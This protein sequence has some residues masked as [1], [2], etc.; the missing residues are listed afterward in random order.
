M[1]GTIIA[2]TLF[3]EVIEVGALNQTQ[4]SGLPACSRD[5][6]LCLPRLERQADS[7]A[8]LAFTWIFGMEWGWVLTLLQTL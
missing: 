3:I 5:P 1:S 2:F 8:H 7:Q 4:S 6:L